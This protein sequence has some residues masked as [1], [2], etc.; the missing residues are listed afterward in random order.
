MTRENIEFRVSFD[1]Q[2]LKIGKKRTELKEGKKERLEARVLGPIIGASA[3]DGLTVRQARGRWSCCDC[4][5]PAWALASRR[6]QY[7]TCPASS[8][9]CWDFE[10]I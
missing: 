10:R 5:C 6:A 2:L 9:S 7:T 4:S 8:I 3:I 1:N